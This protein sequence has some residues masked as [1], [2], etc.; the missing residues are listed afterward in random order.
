MLLLFLLYVIVCLYGIK[1]CANGNNDYLSIDTTTS[2]KG[3]FILLVFFSHFNSYAHLASKTDLIYSS[4]VG[5]FGQTMVTL[6]LFYSGYGVMEAIK[7]KG[8]GY[9]DSFPYKRIL[10]TLFR[11]DCAV[12][13]FLIIGLIFNN[14]YPLKQIILS[15]FGWDSLGNSNWYI[16]VILVLYFITYLAF[17]LIKSENYI[18]QVTVISLIVCLLIISCWYYNIKPMYWYDTALCYAAGMFYSLFRVYIENE[19]RFRHNFLWL[20]SLF[21][22]IGSF[23]VSKSLGNSIAYLLSN[24]LFALVVVCITMRF[25]IGNRILYW[26]GN[27][28]FELYILQRLPMIALKNIGV[29]QINIYLYFALCLIITILLIK[30]FKHFTSLLLKL[31]PFK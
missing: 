14:R 28:L 5:L 4:I 6:F 31:L 18:I 19:S 8:T 11:F 12:L 17:K 10:P 25:H 30:P 16:F 27:N 23:L 29:D 20:T 26:C 3:I 9:I 15:L 7:K 22:L 24:V 13:L 1:F 2:I 21:V